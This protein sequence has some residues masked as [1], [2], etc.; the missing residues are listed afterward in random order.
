M[1][2]SRPKNLK[3]TPSVFGKKPFPW[4]GHPGPI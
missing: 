4:Q 2:A 1:N 3:D